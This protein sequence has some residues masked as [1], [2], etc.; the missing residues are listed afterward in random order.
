MNLRRTDDKMMKSE[1]EFL[2]RRNMAVSD[3]LTYPTLKGMSK[4]LMTRE[5]FACQLELHA[6]CSVET[7][8][9]NQSIAVYGSTYVVATEV[10]SGMWVQG[11]PTDCLQVDKRD[12]KILRKA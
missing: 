3:M 7:A 1:N 6:D 9:A 4:Y 2:A 12:V 10:K 8:Y 5:A 11:S